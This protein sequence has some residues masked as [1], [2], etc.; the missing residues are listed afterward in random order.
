MD[1]SQFQ[2]DYL[3]SPANQKFS[4][5][6]I[7]EFYDYISKQIESEKDIAEEK[8]EQI[9]NMIEFLSQHHVL[10]NDS[11]PSQ[12]V[13]KKDEPEDFIGKLFGQTNCLNP[14]VMKRVFA[15]NNV[16]MKLC[17]LVL[18]DTLDE[19]YHGLYDAS[20]ISALRT[21]VF[22]GIVTDAAGK[23]I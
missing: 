4:E 9:L 14:S 20:A 5:V 3:E 8:S 6:D 1:S 18:C 21:L 7:D 10:I 11:N 17:S 13:I 15:D 16:P 12:R 22:W 23:T 19:L 2:K